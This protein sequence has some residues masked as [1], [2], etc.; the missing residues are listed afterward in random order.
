APLPGTIVL[1]IRN[2][3]TLL[4]LEPEKAAEFKV[5]RLGEGE[6]RTL[7]VLHDG[8]KLSAGLVVRGDDE[9]TP[10][11]VTLKPWGVVTGRLLDARG[12]PLGNVEVNGMDIPRYNPETGGVGPGVLVG[13][14]GRFRIEGLVAGRKYTFR[15]SKNRYGLGLLVR[16]LT[17]QLGESR[18]LGDVQVKAEP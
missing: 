8:R 18:D 1:G 4:P 14:D 12:E 15:A 13:E 3:S 17:L 2:A 11:R 16:D 7:T 5:I 6:E 9:T 10:L